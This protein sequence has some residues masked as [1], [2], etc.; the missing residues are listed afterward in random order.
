[1]AL[2]RAVVLSPILVP[3]LIGG[4]RRAARWPAAGGARE[5]QAGEAGP[6][7]RLLIVGDSS[8]AGGGVTTQGAALSGRLSAEL[9]RDHVVQWRLV[10]R[11]GAVVPDV[12]AMLEDEPGAFDCVLV[13]LGVNDAK[14][15]RA[16]RTFARDYAALLRVL[17]GRFGARCVVCSGLPPV[18]FFPL[19]PRPLRDVLG[20]RVAQFDALIR[21][22]AQAQPGARFLPMDF[23]DDVSQM[24]EDGFHPGPAIYAEWARLA[25]DLMRAD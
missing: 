5:G 19:L 10:A 8:A 23:T 9:A 25:A 22:L 20:A 18:G 17:V 15:G 11:S 7:L 14:N 3:Q 13:C 24:A 4:R 21:R 12:L 2:W 6:A 16:A 1:M